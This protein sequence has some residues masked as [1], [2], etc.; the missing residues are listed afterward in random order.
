MSAHSA[1]EPTRLSV[2]PGLSETRGLHTPTTEVEMVSA[3]GAARAQVKGPTS[4]QPGMGSGVMWMPWMSAL[5][6]EMGGRPR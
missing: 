5:G 2:P 1:V 4:G 6:Q 3:R